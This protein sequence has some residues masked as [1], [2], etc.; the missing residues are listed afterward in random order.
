MQDRRPAFAKALDH[1]LVQRPCPLAATEH[2][3]NGAFFWKPK[4]LARLEFARAHE[5]A[6]V[7]AGR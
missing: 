6:R 5:S 7:A 1:Q 4:L 2:E 3:Q